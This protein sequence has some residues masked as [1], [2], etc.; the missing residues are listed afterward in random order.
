M[1]RHNSRDYLGTESGDVDSDGINEIAGG[2]R[3]GGF[4]RSANCRVII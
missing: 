4:D 1:S 2:T 3:V